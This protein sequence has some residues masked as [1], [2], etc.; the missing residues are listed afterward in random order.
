MPNILVFGT[1]SIGAFYSCILNRGGAR[2]TCICRSNYD[3][4]KLQ[5][6]QIDSSV[7]GQLRSAPVVAKTVANALAS[8]SEPYDYVVVCTKST[9]QTIS[10]TL[11]AIAPAITPS[12]TVIVLVQNGLGVERPYHAAFP[13]VHLISG[14]AYAPTTQIS[15]AVYSHS[16]VER[17]HLG[18]YPALT[19]SSVHSQQLDTFAELIKRGGATAHLTEDIQKERWI[20][21][22]ANGAVNSICALSRC[23]DRE[24]IET[25]RFGAELVHAVM[26][27]IASVACSAG[28]GDVIDQSVVDRQFRRSIERPYPGVQPSMMTDVLERRP[29]EVESI[30]GEV[31]RIAQENEM[32]TP[33]L[34]TL[35]VLLQGLDRAL[36][37]TRSTEKWS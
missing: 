27:E 31:V 18:F 36:S 33:M 1:G 34:I 32:A 25:S 17:L 26:K 22:V 21:V 2:V 35:Y 5:G 23:R 9:V 10:E 16:E 7:L 6:L 4:V 14:V 13:N 29:L 8:S 15:P 3:Q 30:M 20:K 12:I 11:T 28:Y 24:L 19:P 37:T